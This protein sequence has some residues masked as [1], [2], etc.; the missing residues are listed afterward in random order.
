VVYLPVYQEGEPT[1]TVAHRRQ[2]L[3]GFVVG[4]FKAEELF[5]HTFVE[6]ST[7]P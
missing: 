7:P 6:P 1:H 3:R 4:T 5:A 2:A